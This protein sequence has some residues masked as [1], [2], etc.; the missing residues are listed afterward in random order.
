MSGVRERWE[1]IK[2]FLLNRQLAYQNTFVA[3]SPAAD[4]VLKDLARFC[5]AHNTTFHPDPRMHAILEG[6]REV[7]LRIERFLKLTP[8]EVWELHGKVEIE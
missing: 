2:D 4:K 1:R 3:G 6:R 8:E 5:R 7:F